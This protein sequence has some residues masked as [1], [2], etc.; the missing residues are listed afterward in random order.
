MKWILVLYFAGLGNQG[1]MAATSIGPYDN[2]QS[3]LAVGQLMAAKDGWKGFCYPVGDIPL[4]ENKEQGAPA[5]KKSPDKAPD[6][7]LP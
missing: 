3:C 6:E 1:Q 7:K 4:K 5:P 2:K